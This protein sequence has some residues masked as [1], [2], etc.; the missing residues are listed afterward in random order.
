LEEPGKQ[1][2]E[3]SARGLNHSRMESKW[4]HLNDLEESDEDADGVGEA[5]AE[6]AESVVS[7]HNR[8]HHEVHARKH[9]CTPTRSDGEISGTHSMT[10]T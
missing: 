2:G 5:D 7:V 4:Y 10:M 1:Q 9:T 8:V 3:R 6:G